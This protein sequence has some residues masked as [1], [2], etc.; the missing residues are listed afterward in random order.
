MMTGQHAPWYVALLTN[1]DWSGG[2][3]VHTAY[4]HE[5]VLEDEPMRRSVIGHYVDEA[6][7]TWLEG[8]P[9]HEPPR[10]R[11]G[12]SRRVELDHA[13]LVQVVVPPPHR[14]GQVCPDCRLPAPVRSPRPG[15]GRV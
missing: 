15:F 10:A 13:V 11:I 6:L 12:L 1:L 8:W 3:V 5:A 9:G 7:A 14:P 4:G 2:T